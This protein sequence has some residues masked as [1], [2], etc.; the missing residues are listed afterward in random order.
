MRILMFYRDNITY[1]IVNYFVDLMAE[2]LRNIGVQVDLFDVI[3]ENSSRD[4]ARLAQALN[5]NH[6]DAAYTV[7]AVGQQSITDENNEC[8]FDKYDIPFFNRLIDPPY[9][10]DIRSRAKNYYILFNDKEYIEF[11]KHYY[12]G[13][14]DVFFF[15]HF[16]ASDYRVETEGEFAKRQYPV[17]FTGSY[18]SVEGMISRFVNPMSQVEKDI[19]FEALDILLDSREMSV[20]NALL[21]VIKDRTGIELKVGQYANIR[22]LFSYLNVFISK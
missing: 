11:T 14:K 19:F 8:I 9:F 17:V 7:D 18:E 12:P 22:H 21:N 10:L 5:E 6:Y 13:V 15:P 1:D 16:A 3:G 4:R 20:E 2:G